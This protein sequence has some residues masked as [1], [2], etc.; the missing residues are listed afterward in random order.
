[1]AVASLLATYPVACTLGEGLHFCARLNRLFWVDIKAPALFAMCLQSRE[2]ERIAMPE[3]IGWI[4]ETSEGRWIAGFQSGVYWLNAHFEQAGKVCELPN[5]PATN[6]LN[7]AKSD[8]EGRLYFGSMDN[9]E[10]QPSGKLYRL[11]AEGAAE[12][13]H[14]YVVSNGPAFSVSGEYLYTVSSADRVIYR[15][16]VN[17]AGGLT[18]K[19]PFIQFSASDGYPDGLTV[20]A[21]DRI[22]VACW[23]GYGIRCYA[24][25]GKL[26]R[27]IMLPAPQV[28]N[29]LFA[30]SAFDTLFVTTARIG[31]NDTL[32]NRYPLSGAV[33]AL[34]V[35]QQGIA[36]QPVALTP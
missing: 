17:N 20:D 13:D 29:V 35:K 7:D 16:K 24:P 12:V 19:Q 2:I 1:M 27:H 3:P 21:N 4:K 26:I 33:F 28:T 23:Q 14:G 36:E 18:D 34:D 32:L 9:N 25:T 11:S 15:A 8:R 22:W 5:E 30:G 10:L 31:L 6:R